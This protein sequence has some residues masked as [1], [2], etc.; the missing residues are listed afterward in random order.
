MR[1]RKIL[2]VCL[3]CGSFLAGLSVRELPVAAQADGRGAS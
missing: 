1:T 3:M 2:V